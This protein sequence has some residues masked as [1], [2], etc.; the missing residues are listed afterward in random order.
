M[1]PSE[2]AE[3]LKILGDLV[4]AFIAGVGG[5]FVSRQLS[6]S[7]IKKT[8]SE[9]K[10]QEADA[11]KELTDTVLLLMKPL[12]DE[13]E[14]LSKRLDETDV[15]LPETKA[16]LCTTQEKLQIY[17]RGVRVLIAQLKKLEIDPEWIPP[18]NNENKDEKKRNPKSSP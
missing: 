16:E 9:A 2:W 13:I 15:E 3:I 1:S 4:I 11:A 6:K 17:V 12:R 8:D 10:K 14:R 18:E 7:T 5:F